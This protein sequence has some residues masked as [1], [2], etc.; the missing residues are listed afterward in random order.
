LSYLITIC[1]KNKEIFEKSEN[2]LIFNLLNLLS[3]AIN[4][5]LKLSMNTEEISRVL[6]CACELFDLYFPEDTPKYEMKLLIDA[7]ILIINECMKKRIIPKCI[8]EFLY[9]CCYLGIK[10]EE[11]YNLFVE[12]EN[13]RMSVNVDFLNIFNYLE[14]L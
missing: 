14:K 11:K 1:K 8:F 12:Y 10:K 3:N 6:R 7:I 13:K 5:A 9:K 2:I 4:R